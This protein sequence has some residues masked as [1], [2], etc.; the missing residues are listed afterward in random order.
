MELNFG[1]VFGLER[2]Y[3]F[4]PNL[5]DSAADVDAI[6][7]T[8]ECFQNDKNNVGGMMGGGD[9]ADVPLQS[10]QEEEM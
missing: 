10:K 3:V 5:L 7:L 4:W 1:S 6:I 8:D 9:G 2:L